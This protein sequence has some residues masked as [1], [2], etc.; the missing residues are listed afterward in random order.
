MPAL[1]YVQQLEKNEINKQS[2]VENGKVVL[3][4]S[5]EGLVDRAAVQSNWQ[6]KGTWREGADPSYRRYEELVSP[7]VCGQ[8]EGTCRPAE[9]SGSEFNCTGAVGSNIVITTACCLQAD[10]ESSSTQ[11]V[12]RAKLLPEQ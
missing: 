10:A 1:I 9:C 3:L 11:Y 2:R 8:Q 6:R 5:P 7:R 12:P 4:T